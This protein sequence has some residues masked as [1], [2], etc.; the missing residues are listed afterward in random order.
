MSNNTNGTE[1]AV[2]TQAK[3]A[4]GFLGVPLNKVLLD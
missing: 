4:M 1:F 3:L 2:L